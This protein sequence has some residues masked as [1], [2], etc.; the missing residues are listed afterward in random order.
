MSV[1]LY[2]I[3]LLESKIRLAYH[4]KLTVSIKT[5]HIFF[6]DFAGHKIASA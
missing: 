2:D 1:Y 3:L 5:N 4:K 6:I